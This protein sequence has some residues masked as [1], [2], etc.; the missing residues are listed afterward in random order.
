MIGESTN[1]MA[2]WEKRS[3]WLARWT[4]HRLLN[5]TDLWAKYLPTQKRRHSTSGNPR[6]YRLAPLP[7]KRGKLKLTERL[8]ERHY[9]GH[10]I[11]HILG[12]QAASADNT[13]KWIAINLERG[14]RQAVPLNNLR[15]ASH[16]R[17]ELI[18]MGFRPLMIDTNGAGG[19]C[20][21]TLFREPLPTAKAYD[22]VFRLVSDYSDAGLEERPAILPES[23]T[24]DE[25]NWL[26]LPGRDPLSGHWSRVWNG[27]HWLQG[28][29]AV[30]ALLHAHGDAPTLIRKL[31]VPAV[32]ASASGGN[33]ATA[34]T[35]PRAEPPAEPPRPSSGSLGQDEESLVLCYLLAA[36]RSDNP[37]TAFAAVGAA[38]INPEAFENPVYRH[39][40]QAL[41][42]LGEQQTHITPTLIGQQISDNRRAAAL[43]IIDQL[44]IQ[45]PV[46]DDEFETLLANLSR[47]QPVAA[48]GAPCD[49]D[50]P[51]AP[52]SDSQVDQILQLWPRLSP[53]MRQALLTMA[54]SAGR[55]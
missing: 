52:E 19:Y 43:E 33:G 44:I 6:V 39:I 55:E 17:E 49:S 40:F 47:R 37:A 42:R 7:A 5:R 34:A 30:E 35:P 31:T 18:S 36:T 10:D 41:V 11:G 24:H 53:A 9:R 48:S 54:Q 1:V 26:R 16:W 51:V 46:S 45:K 23:A 29:D 28:A 22:F 27:R 4:L 20:L 15:A 2:A 21:L 12:I 14:D 32:A 25:D 3:G 50:R 13:S 38:D 8:L